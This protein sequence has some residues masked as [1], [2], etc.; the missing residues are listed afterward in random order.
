M[1]AHHLATISPDLTLAEAL[2]ATRIRGVADVSSVDQVP[3]PGEVSL[4]HHGLLCLDAR[5]ACIGHAL[6]VWRQPLEG[7]VTEYNLPGVLD[8]NILAAIGAWLTVRRDSGR[9]R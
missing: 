3:M 8:L 7:E 6:D 1:L 2:E 9:A 4:A 5:P